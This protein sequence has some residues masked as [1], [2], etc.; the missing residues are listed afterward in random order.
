[1]YDQL[2]MSQSIMRGF[3]HDASFYWMPRPNNRGIGRFMDVVWYASAQRL[4]LGV[5]LIYAH[6]GK[7]LILFGIFWNHTWTNASNW[8]LPSH[9]F[10]PIRRISH[11]WSIIGMGNIPGLCRRMLVDPDWYM[12]HPNGTPYARCVVVLGVSVQILG[13]WVVFFLGCCMGRFGV[14]CFIGLRTYIGPAESHVPDTKENESKMR[15]WMGLCGNYINYVRARWG[16]YR[17]ANNGRK[18]G[19][20]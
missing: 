17:E 1:M 14:R 2:R 6:R 19:N 18:S 4:A 15:K 11:V 16:P 8:G 3:T 20:I 5:T 13:R 9:A 10:G 7:L 12:P